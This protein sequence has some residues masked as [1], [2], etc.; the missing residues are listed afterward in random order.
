MRLLLQLSSGMTTMG[1]NPPFD[2]Q[3]WMAAPS[4]YRQ[5]DQALCRV[6]RGHE[7]EIW[8]DGTPTPPS[9]AAAP[10]TSTSTPEVTRTPHRPK[11]IASTRVKS[12]PGARL[13][14]PII[15]PER[16]SSHRP[17][18][19]RRETRLQPHGAPSGELAKFNIRS[20]W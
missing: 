20:K 2:W 8:C 19:P 4:L 7:A 14:Y 3:K 12:E 10:D 16:T 11:S 15:R 13:Q 5:F 6:H 18:T 9:P 1:R 17:M